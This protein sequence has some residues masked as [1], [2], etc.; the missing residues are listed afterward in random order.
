MNR[1]VESH[2]ALNPTSLDIPR[3]QFDRS[4]G[5][6]LTMNTGELVPFFI[7]EVYPGTSIKLRSRNI[8]T[9]RI[10]CEMRFYITIH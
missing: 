3:S 8:K 9:R 7:D 4:S 1:N 6:T 5:V 2:F 10:K